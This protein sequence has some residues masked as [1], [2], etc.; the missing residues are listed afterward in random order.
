MSSRYLL[1]GKPKPP[2]KD[3]RWRAEIPLSSRS[4]S[5][6]RTAADVGIAR[7]GEYELIDVR[8]W[9]KS[10]VTDSVLEE[11]DV[12][13]YRTSE[14]GVRMLWESPHFGQARRRSRA[15]PGSPWACCSA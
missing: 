11:G 15:R 2:T 6:G 12:L 4:V 3:L 1:K 14:T 8:R 7:T 9:G 10:V 13:V 5:V